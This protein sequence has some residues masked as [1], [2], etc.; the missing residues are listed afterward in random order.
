MMSNSVIKCV[1]LCGIPSLG[2]QYFPYGIGA[3]TS[4]T[5][6]MIPRCQ[7]VGDLSF[8]SFIYVSIT[9]NVAF[10]AYEL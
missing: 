4:D 8:L 5:V 3:L 6:S 2:K 10:K 1:T 7:I 9:D